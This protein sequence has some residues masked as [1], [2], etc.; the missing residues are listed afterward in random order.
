M[1][2]LHR[3][4]AKRA[5]R[6]LAQGLGGSAVTTAVVA[7]VVALAEGDAGKAALVA[8]GVAI[9]NTVI[10]AGASFWQAVAAGLPEVQGSQAQ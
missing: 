6:T 10:T 5:Y 9:A 8:A 1:K 2:D 7:S 4:A 3:A